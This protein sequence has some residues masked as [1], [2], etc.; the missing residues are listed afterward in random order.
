MKLIILQELAGLSNILSN[1]LVDRDKTLISGCYDPETKERLKSMYLKFWNKPTYYTRFP[2]PTL[3]SVFSEE[4]RKMFHIDMPFPQNETD[5]NIEDCEYLLCRGTAGGSTVLKKGME[6]PLGNKYPMIRLSN[7]FSTPKS[8]YR[9]ID[10]WN[11]S[12]E[13]ELNLSDKQRFE[14]VK[15]QIFRKPSLVTMGYNDITWIDIDDFFMENKIP[16]LIDYIQQKYD[17]YI[18]DFTYWMLDYLNEH[19]L[20]E[21]NN[22]KVSNQIIEMTEEFNDLTKDFDIINTKNI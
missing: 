20:P 9:Y 12:D 5:K 7:I 8:F 22:I 10:S 6:T 16:E 18:D 14:N 3:Y 1:L 13:K 11:H 21:Y 19:L 2:A 4:D 17:I 15:N